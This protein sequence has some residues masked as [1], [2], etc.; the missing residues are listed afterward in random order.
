MSKAKPGIQHHVHP[1]SYPRFI[2]DGHFNGFCAWTRP[3]KNRSPTSVH[4][5]FAT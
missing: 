2:L 3:V 4:Y 5:R 1:S